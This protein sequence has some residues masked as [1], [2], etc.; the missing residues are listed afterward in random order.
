M[1]GI[2]LSGAI[3]IALRFGIAGILPSKTQRHGRKNFR[4]LI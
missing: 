2:G 1:G 4:S 3:F